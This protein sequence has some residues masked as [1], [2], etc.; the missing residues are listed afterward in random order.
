MTAKTDA[1]FTTK[2]RANKE[3]SFPHIALAGL[4]LLGMLGASVLLHSPLLLTACFVTMGFLAFGSIIAL[5]GAF[6]QMKLRKSY[7][8]FIGALRQHGVVKIYDK[9]LYGGT[10]IVATYHLTGNPNARIDA[11]LAD[12]GILIECYGNE[13]LGTATKAAQRIYSMGVPP[14]HI[15]IELREPSLM[16]TASETEPS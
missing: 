12:N 10:N 5:N 15:H 16:Q 13:A 9:E 14:R 6:R 1:S 3:T 2:R 11:T 4:T 7:G 8:Y